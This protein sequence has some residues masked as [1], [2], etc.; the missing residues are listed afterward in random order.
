MHARKNENLTP[1]QLGW[2]A[3]YNSLSLPSN[4]GL[5]LFL[6]LLFAG[7]KSVAKKLLLFPCWHKNWTVRETKGFFVRIFNFG[8]SFRDFFR[9]ARTGKRDR[10]SFLSVS[11]RSVVARFTSVPSRSQKLFFF[12]RANWEIGACVI[13][14]RH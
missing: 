8:H 3:L 14:I 1:S 9:A 2:P 12:R 4:E 11:H 7:N 13:F 6:L 10:A 5:L